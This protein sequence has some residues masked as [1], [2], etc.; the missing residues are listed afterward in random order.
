M[1]N[2]IVRLTDRAVRAQGL[3]GEKLYNCPTIRRLAGSPAELVPS[4]GGGAG[5]ADDHLDDGPQVLARTGHVGVADVLQD[6]AVHGGD[7]DPGEGVERDRA[8][9][10]GVTAC[11][12]DP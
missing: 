11:L 2:S 10:A 8:D 7:Q 3:V 12:L 1:S 6:D 4:G 9:P 5:Q